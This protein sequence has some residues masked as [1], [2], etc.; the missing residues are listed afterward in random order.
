[1][2]SPTEVSVPLRSV[3]MR[4]DI[5]GRTPRH[6]TCVAERIP[7]NLQA[8]CIAASRGRCLGRERERVALLNVAFD[9]YRKG[10]NCN[11]DRIILRP[12]LEMGNRYEVEFSSPMRFEI[13]QRA[14][15]GVVDCDRGACWDDLIKAIFVEV[16]CGLEIPNRL[17]RV[18]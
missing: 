3:R 9:S 14:E 6:T 15:S 10:I 7:K 5:R 16:I 8:A 17:V 1:M 12:I 18:G 2:I 4:S 11:T 13:V